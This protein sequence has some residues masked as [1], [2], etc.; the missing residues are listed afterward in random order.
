MNDACS[1]RVLLKCAAWFPFL[2]KVA[3]VRILILMKCKYRS[4]ILQPNAESECVW[5]VSLHS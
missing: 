5:P 3:S 1:A 4:C 2:Y